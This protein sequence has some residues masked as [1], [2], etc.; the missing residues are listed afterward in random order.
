MLYAV[1][2]FLVVVA[3]SVHGVVR[4]RR[5]VRDTTM[6]IPFRIVGTF[7]VVPDAHRLVLTRGGHPMRALTRPGRPQPD[8]YETSD[9]IT[10]EE[11]MGDYASMVSAVEQ[12]KHEDPAFLEFLGRPIP[13]LGPARLPPVVGPPPD[14]VP[15]RDVEVAVRRRMSGAIRPWSGAT[16]TKMVKRDMFAALDRE[17]KRMLCALDDGNRIAVM[18]TFEVLRRIE[19]MDC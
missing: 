3:A 16:L 4:W 12:M 10:R 1:C 15:P 6:P 8:Y 7:P 2:A 11:P 9:G 18:T 19:G 17:W 14:P 13:T 5:R